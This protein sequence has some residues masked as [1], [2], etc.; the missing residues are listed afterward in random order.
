MSDYR[1]MHQEAVAAA[2]GKISDVAAVL[3]AVRE[4]TQEAIAATVNA[5]G[6][7]DQVESAG[8]VLG[9]LARIEADAETSSGLAANAEAELDRYSGGF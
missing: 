3:A 6:D 8:N 9:I 5:V 7:D 2:K 4:K 1:A